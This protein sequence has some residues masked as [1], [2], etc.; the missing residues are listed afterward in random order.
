MVEAKQVDLDTVNVTFD[1]PMEDVDKNITVYQVVGST[2]VKQT[3]SKVEM[4]EDKK[5][6]SV[7]LYIPFAKGSTY[8]VEYPDMES[9]SFIAATTNAEDVASMIVYTTTAVVNVEKEVEVKLYNAEGV[10]ITTP[11]L[12]SRVSMKSAGEAGTWF[13]SDTKKVLIFETG[14]TTVITAT[15]QTYKYDNTGKPIGN[16]EAVGTIVGVD[17]DATNITG[18]AAWTMVPRKADGSYDVN[19]YDVKQILAADDYNYRLFVKLDEK[20]G[21]NSSAVESNDTSKSSRFDYTSSDRSV[22]IVDQLGN[23]YPVKEGTVTVVVKYAAAGDKV[24]VATVTINVGPKKAAS[25]FTLSTY[26][27]SLSNTK[28][29]GGSGDYLD[30]KL[31]MKDQAERPF[32]FTK[33]NIERLS[34]PLVDGNMTND[35]LVDSTGDVSVSPTNGEVD[36]RF[37]ANDKKEGTYVYKITVENISRVVTINVVKANETTPSYYRLVLDTTSKD[38][39]IESWTALPVNVGIKLFGYSSN[40]V[41]VVDVDLT[42][43]TDDFKIEVE[44]PWDPN[45]KFVSHKRSDNTDLKTQFYSVAKAETVTGVTGSVIYKAP[46]GSYKVTAY[47][48]VT[49]NGTTTVK[50]LDTVYFTTTDTQTP[51]VLSEIKSQ[52]FTGTLTDADV[53]N[54][55]STNLIN[56]VKGDDNNGLKFKVDGGDVE[57]VE[58]EAVGTGNTFAVK[59]VTVR[60]LIKGEAGTTSAVYLDY[61]V[62][63]GLTFERKN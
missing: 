7:S 30:V 4:D 27:F 58:V 18:L 56:A 8:S 12:L 2:K 47:G 6:A 31:T 10:D 29:L 42:N 50:A 26:E 15:Y 28:D 24:P 5:V 55:K 39:K 9:K 49:E 54:S 23:L 34:A 57:I 40:G 59:S 53:I 37:N 1:S 3:I 22:L 25:I 43:A 63:V 38:M 36:V 19:F 35:Q 60:K 45:G 20:T 16:I 62:N 48:P 21:N 33:Y 51:A 61:K 44:A 41:K 32:N 11:E 46:V 13:N 17:K 52:V 14:K